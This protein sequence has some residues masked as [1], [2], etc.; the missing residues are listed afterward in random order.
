MYLCLS[1]FL[2]V[3]VYQ[4]SISLYLSSITYLCIYL[5]SIY[6][7]SFSKLSTFL[8]NLYIESIIY[9]NIIYVISLYISQSISII[10]LYIIYI[11]FFSMYVC[12]LKNIVTVTVLC[13]FLFFVS[14]KYNLTD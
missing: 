4:S 9:V 14:G 6:N 8:F 5:P 2:S 12:I 11:L 10:Y 7:L 3:S 13:L 1:V